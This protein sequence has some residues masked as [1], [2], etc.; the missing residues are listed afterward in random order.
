MNSGRGPI[1]K[2]WVVAGIYVALLLASHG[3]RAFRSPAKSDRSAR[4]VT[5]SAVAGD[6][7]I[8]RP[9]TISYRDYPSGAG[10]QAP[11]VVAVHG[12][13]GRASD[14]HRMAPLLARHYHVIAPDL[15]G[16]GESTHAVPDYSIRAHARYVLE[17]LDAL[18]IERAHLIGFS[19]GGGVV[20][21]IADLGPDRV[22][23]I[24]MVS[25]IG[26]QEMELLGDYHLNHA[27][28]GA[29]LAGLW[30]MRELVPHFGWLDGAMMGV[31]YARNFYDSDQRPLRDE[32][33]R[34]GGPMLILHGE[35]DVLVPVEAAR[36]H[37]RI[38]PQS[39]IQLFDDD[40]FMA[41][42]RPEKLTPAIESFL[43]DVDNGRAPTRET[44]DPRLVA[45]SNQPFNP[46][47]VPRAKGVAG[48]VLLVL[49]VT[50]TFVSE[51]LTSIGVGVMVAQGRFS[52]LFGAVSCFL[53]I[54]VGDV[55]LF[56]AGRWL[57]RPALRRAPLSWFMSRQAVERSSAW[58][59]RKGLFVVLASRFA[60]GARL[61]TYFAAGML[62]TRTRWVFAYFL[63]AG[64]I[65][66]PLLV[67]ASAVLGGKALETTLFGGNGLLLR[68]AVVAGI[69]YAGVKLLVQFSSYRGRRLALSWWRRK[70]RWEFWPP[71]V[72]YVPV[73]LYVL[74]LGLRHR[75][76]TVFTA[77][78]P[79]IPAGGFI[80]ESKT[81]ILNGLGGNDRSVARSRLL[82]GAVNATAR[83]AQAEEFMSANQLSYPIVLKPDA[84]QRG[85]GV[86]IVRTR[87]AL[88]EYLLQSDLDTI[89]QEYV[90]GLEFGVFYYRR[91]SEPNGQIFSITEKRF[92]VVIG[93]GTST[94]ERLIL[95]DD[96]AVCMARYYIDR[97]GPA[98]EDTPATG[99]R[100]QLVEIGTHCKGAVF[101]DGGWI[102]TD[103]LA[104]AIDA[105]SRT[106]A[107]F[108][109]GRF[110][111]R[112][113][114]IEDLAEG[115]NFKVIE[116]NGVTSEATHIY[117]PK[118]PLREAYRVL[119]NQWRLAFEIGAANRALGARPTPVRALVRAVLEYRMR[120]ATDE[121][122]SPATCAA[123][124]S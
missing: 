59:R 96:R 102:K 91:P 115:R 43:K 123:E 36:E 31:E 113:P 79:G 26:V 22:E 46:A 105:V 124:E 52:Y 68:A 99:E 118:N 56:A 45:L 24:S 89:I 23:S 33:A 74:Y 100:I 78:N 49:I 27:L 92:P 63:I 10:E 109:F 12:S 93:N 4:T 44:A 51:D 122:R 90:P 37:H 39:S 2:R 53:G 6:Q 106:F 114:S 13:P 104:R 103:K 121:V 30:M 95:S 86:A 14:F 66:T 69:L 11:V 73:V 48:L 9:V 25:A 88:E 40:H 5:V 20:L 64:A 84:G 3:L 76:L 21:N 1:K 60:P 58:F 97:Q 15:P 81:E 38:V 77:A 7:L 34:Y 107:G 17:L 70:T 116:L 80:G 19:M 82:S 117:D 110:D 54:F 41:F 65:W 55:L 42:M 47:S 71:Y 87:S 101:L 29:Q 98:A 94:L 112:T 108:C 8:E 83:M 67:G 120:A 85:S 28:H 57:G 75:S 18:G 35:H 16:F 50:A 32:M 61:P 111:I 119:F 62:N 72:F